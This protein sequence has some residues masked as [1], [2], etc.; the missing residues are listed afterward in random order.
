[1]I[2]MRY[3]ASAAVPA[4]EAGRRAGGVG[5]VLSIE[6]GDTAA[7]SPCR[8]LHPGSSFL[9]ARRLVGAAPARKPSGARSRGFA[10]LYHHCIAH[11]QHRRSAGEL[12]QLALRDQLS[13]K[14]GKLTATPHR[15][16]FDKMQTALADFIKG[17][18]SGRP[19]GPTKDSAR[20]WPLWLLMLATCPPTY[21]Q[22]DAMNST[23]RVDGSAGS[24]GCWRA[25]QPLRRCAAQRSLSEL[26][27]LRDA[28][29]RVSTITGCW[30]SG[31]NR[32]NSRCRARSDNALLRRL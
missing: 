16:A 1:M 22:L 4:S 10:W 29:R 11:H 31:A 17:H 21:R 15:T 28:C 26:P 6:R 30:I 3:C 24:S 14:H 5:V 7:R 18:R 9:R 19:L 25:S 12:P 13:A 2:A 32:S 20:L 27:V 8:V 23:A